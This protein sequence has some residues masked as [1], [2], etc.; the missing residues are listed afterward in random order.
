MVRW[1]KKK[2]WMLT[3]VLL[4]ATLLGVSGLQVSD[5]ANVPYGQV[6][7]GMGTL[8]QSYPDQPVGWEDIENAKY[9]TSLARKNEDKTLAPQE[10][11]EVLELFED[12]NVIIIDDSTGRYV[13]YT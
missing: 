13:D 8:H 9:F 5:R 2:G 3:C 6:G 10:A 1:L 4:V 12:D 11:D 7:K